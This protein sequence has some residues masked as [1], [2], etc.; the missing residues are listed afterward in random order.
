MAEPLTKGTFKKSSQKPLTRND[1]HIVSDDREDFQIQVVTLENLKSAL[2]EFERLCDEEFL[3]TYHHN[4]ETII[5][6][7]V[8]Q[9]TKLFL[10]KAFPAIYEKEANK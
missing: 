2:E 4:A 6:E 9:T 8:F 1:I 5:K 7:Q 3:L 10:K